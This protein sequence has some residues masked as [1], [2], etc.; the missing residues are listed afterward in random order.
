MQTQDAGERHSG[1]CDAVRAGT[2]DAPPEKPRDDGGRNLVEVYVGRLRRKFGQ[3]GVTDPI[4]TVR[5]L[6]YRL[7]AG[8]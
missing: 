5:G 6:G 8:P 4:A 7:E 3:A 2:P 1:D